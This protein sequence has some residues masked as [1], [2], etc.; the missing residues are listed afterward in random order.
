MDAICKK[1]LT[2]MALIWMGCFVVFLSV[3]VLVLAPHHNQKVRM[4][5]QLAEQK[6]TYEDVSKLTDK[7]RRD[8]LNEELEALKGHLS[9]FVVNFEDAANLTF[10][11]RQIA[12]ENNA[13]AFSIQTRIAELNQKKAKFEHIQQ[14]QIELDFTSDFTEFAI[15]LNALERH[16]PVIFVDRF[17]IVRSE[18]S[19]SGHQVDMNL[20]VLVKKQE[21]KEE[22]IGLTG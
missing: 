1:Y 22:R 18:K 11:I 13:S 14:N 4:D 8:E 16:K 3:Y 21:N 5:K 2:T 6:K 15:F 9:Q 7:Q 20:S 10:D 19:D 17:S 12:K